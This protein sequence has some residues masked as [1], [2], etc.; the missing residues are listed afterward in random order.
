MYNFGVINV[1]DEGDDHVGDKQDDDNEDDKTESDKDDIY[2]YKIRVRKDEDEKIKDALVEGSKK[3]D[4]E[5]T[6]ATKEEAEKT[7]E[8]KDDTKKTELP[9]SSSS[10]YVSS[11]FEKDVSELKIVDHSFEALVVLQ[12]YVPIV[13]DSYLDTKVRDKGSEDFVVYYDASNQGFGYVL[14]QRGK[15]ELFSD[16]DCE[17]HY[18]PG[19]ANVVADAF[20]RKERVK[21]RRVRAM[22]MTIQSS[23][24][25]KILAAQGEASKVGNVTAEMLRGLDQQMEKNE[26]GGLYFID[27]GWDSVD[28]S[29]WTVYNTF[30]ENITESLRDTIGYEYG[31]SSSDG[32][33]KYHLSIRCA[34]F[35]ALY[36]K[37]CRSPVLWAEIEESRLIG[38][39]LVQEMTDKVVL[40]KEKLKAARDR[41]KSY[42]DNRRKPLEFE[43]KCLADAKLHVPLDE[44]KIDK[45]IR[46][47]E[48]PIEIINCE[49]KS[50][51]R[52]KIPIVK[53][54]W[55][56]KHGPEFT[57]ER[58]DYMKAKY[59]RLFAYCAVKPTS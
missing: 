11:G 42:V 6:D 2:K 59:L 33:I 32:W 13:V 10:L 27:R 35:E 15:I 39:E 8:E 20:S 17:I 54:R 3:G 34:S 21:L 40:I 22:S 31:L 28:R 12:S 37:K 51:K 24:T 38:P 50:L 49:V 25:Y 36:G 47:I 43:K 53:V 58:E 5:I 1:D 29:R 41:Q 14:M 56:S 19:K 26:D 48:E 44:V 18:H 46:F 52:S 45:T 55:N 16:Y 23:V 30:L 9:P 7:L 4:E 57:G